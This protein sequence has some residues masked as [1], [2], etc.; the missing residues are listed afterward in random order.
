MYT[1]VYRSRLASR[2]LP[3]L[4]CSNPMVLRYKDCPIPSV[5]AHRE[6]PSWNRVPTLTPHRWPFP[7]ALPRLLSRL[8]IWLCST[9]WSEVSGSCTQPVFPLAFLLWRRAP[10]D[11]HILNMLTGPYWNLHVRSPRLPQSRSR[12]FLVCNQRGAD[13]ITLAH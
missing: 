9:K 5:N 1:A 8:V 3:A 13:R 7:F 11:C 4:P 12:N 2:T 6:R 10:R